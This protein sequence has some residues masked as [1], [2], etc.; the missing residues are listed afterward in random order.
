MS[1]EVSL[2]L[3]SEWRIDRKKL[4][5]LVLAHR[6]FRRAFFAAFRC[7]FFFAFASVA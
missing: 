5:A 7:S 1:D 2:L 4:V 3:R 6:F